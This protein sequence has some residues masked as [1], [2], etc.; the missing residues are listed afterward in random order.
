MRM[1]FEWLFIDKNSHWPYS[2]IYPSSTYSKKTMELIAEFQRKEA[3]HVDGLP[4][5][6]LTLVIICTLKE[7][8]VLLIV[9]KSY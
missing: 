1:L 6:E 2:H 8:Y 3:L 7:W 9:M 5:K 4:T